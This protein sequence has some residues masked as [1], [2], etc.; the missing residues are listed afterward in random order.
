M[1]AHF[2]CAIPKLINI[3]CT[4]FTYCSCITPTPFSSHSYALA[5]PLP[6]IR[7]SAHAH[8][9]SYVWM[10]QVEKWKSVDVVHNVYNEHKNGVERVWD[11]GAEQKVYENGSKSIYEWCRN[12]GGM[13]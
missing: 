6:H 11:V 9:E 8:I 4:S 5:A 2:H 12:S 10:V 13:L 3:V 1:S 7:T